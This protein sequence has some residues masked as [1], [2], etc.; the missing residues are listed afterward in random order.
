ISTVCGALMSVASDLPQLVYRQQ[1]KLA[2][3]SYLYDD[4]WQPIG[5]FAPPNH[6]VID[7]YGRIAPSMRDAIVVVEDRRF[8]TD[9]G[10]DLRGIGRAFVAYPTGGATPGAPT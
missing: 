10:I 3:N 1:Y 9:P 2:A 5:I 7:T 4:H 6:V 8:W